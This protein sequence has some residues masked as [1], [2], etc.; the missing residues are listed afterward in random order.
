MNVGIAGPRTAAAASGFT[1]LMNALFGSIAEPPPSPM[2]RTADVTR[3]LAPEKKI[4]DAMIRSMLGVCR[5]GVKTNA[6][7]P[8]DAQGATYKQPGDVILQ[9]A[10]AKTIPLVE[11]TTVEPNPPSPQSK[12]VDP[13]NDTTVIASQTPVAFEATLTPVQTTSAQDLTETPAPAAASK[14]NLLAPAAE[15]KPLIHPE[16]APRVLAVAQAAASSDSFAR[17]FEAPAPAAPQISASDAKAATT[18]G[19]IP[20]ALRTSETPAAAAV[21]VNISSAHDIAVRISRPD[22]PAVDLHIAERAGEI[23]VA[24]RTAD[25][26]LATSLRQD[27]PA[28]ANSLERAGFRAETFV[29]HQGIA[30]AAQSSKSNSQDDRQQQSPRDS[31]GQDANS[32]SQG[33]QQRNRDRNLQHWLNEMEKQS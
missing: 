28:L 30:Q 4:A 6:Q 7:H 23:H 22:M 13:I 2:A 26:P 31:S 15:I 3:K 12:S 24:V 29:P 5:E 1:N 10:V 20:Q 14:D 17:A 19:T 27:L 25:A 8:A 9:V 11:E 33:R 21:P 18:F 32:F 16:D